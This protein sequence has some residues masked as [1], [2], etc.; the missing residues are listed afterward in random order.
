MGGE[1][2]AKKAI[3]H[4]EIVEMIRECC[5][6]GQRIAMSDIPQALRAG[7]GSRLVTAYHGQY[8]NFGDQLTPLL[9]DHYGWRAVFRHYKPRFWPTPPEIVS[10]GTLLQNTPREYDGL[11]LGTGSDPTGVSRCKGPCT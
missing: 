1:D 6:S 5:R 10:V 11:I 4:V 9:L 7:F 8:P 3:P 2:V